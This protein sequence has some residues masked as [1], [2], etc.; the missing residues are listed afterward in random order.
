MKD[1]NDNRTEHSTGDFVQ[2]M[3]ETREFIMNCD[4]STGPIPPAKNR[5][6]KFYSPIPAQN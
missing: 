4:D 2:F 6:R 3:R 1:E 5:Y